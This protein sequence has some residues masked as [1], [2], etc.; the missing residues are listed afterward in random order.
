MAGE[1]VH[2]H[3]RG[4][5]DLANWDGRQQS[6]SPPH[7]WGRRDRARLAKRHVRFTPTC[8]GTAFLFLYHSTL[9]PVHP[10][11]RGDGT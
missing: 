5:G 6:G 7:A 10:H 2:P 9:L 8:V 4:D 1:S 11:M 3:M